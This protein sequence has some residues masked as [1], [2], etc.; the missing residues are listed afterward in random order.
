MKNLHSLSTS[1]NE[2]REKE[3]GGKEKGKRGKEKG[4]EINRDGYHSLLR[5]NVIYLGL[6][7]KRKA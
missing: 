4:G 1:V 7:I 6:K 3:L 5:H 2:C